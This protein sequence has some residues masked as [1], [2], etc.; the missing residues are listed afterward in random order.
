[1]RAAD[2]REGL[3]VRFLEEVP[4][5]VRAEKGKGPR[6][7]ELVP[8]LLQPHGRLRVAVPPEHVD[9]LAVEARPLERAVGRAGVD[10]AADH[11]DEPIR[12]GNAVDHERVQGRARVEERQPA[13]GAGALDVDPLGHQRVPEFAAVRFGGDHH[14]RFVVDE[15]G[16]EVASDGLA[17]EGLVLV[18]LDGMLGGRGGLAQRGVRCMAGID[19]RRVVL[20]IDH[21][22]S[23][24]R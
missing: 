18:E 12:I 14:H 1:M 16:A 10:G 9:H 7:A 15:S 5:H 3:A 11:G 21:V 13:G 2:A 20:R 22:A 8:Q 19:D 23:F 4:H 17:E 6:A 24:L